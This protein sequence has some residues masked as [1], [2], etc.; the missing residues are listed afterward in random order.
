MAERDSAAA[1]G[2]LLVALDEYF[3]AAA[4]VA[5]P[6][7]LERDLGASPVAR[8]PAVTPADHGGWAREELAPKWR[9]RVRQRSYWTWRRGVAATT[10]L[11]LIAAAAWV[12]SIPIPPPT[13]H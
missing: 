8:Q 13:I 10:S 5:E 3:V 9:R 4:T 12:Q 7:A 2:S 11:A 6:S 1:S